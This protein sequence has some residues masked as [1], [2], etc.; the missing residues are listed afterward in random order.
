MDRMVENPRRVGAIIAISQVD[1]DE[2]NRIAFHRYCEGQAEI[3]DVKSLRD[4][5]RGESESTLEIGRDSVADT[6]ADMQKRSMYPFQSM[7]VDASPVKK[8]DFKSG[9]H[10]DATNLGHI[11]IQT[12]TKMGHDPA[13]IDRVH[14]RSPGKNEGPIG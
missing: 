4:Q 2:Q 9:I 6:P 8:G 7:G 13:G 5:G 1:S 12:Y 10:D 3:N 14:S 11:R